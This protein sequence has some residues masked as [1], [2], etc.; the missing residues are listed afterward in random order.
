M[1]SDPLRKALAVVAMLIG[2]AAGGLPV[3]ARAQAADAEPDVGTPSEAAVQFSKWVAASGDNNGVP[4]VIVD[5]IAAVVSVYDSQGNLLGAEPALL[6][7]AHG[8]E[9]APGI[10]SRDLSRISPEERTT[11]AGRFLANFGRANGKQKVLWVDFSTAISL[12]A[13][14]TTNKAEQRLERLQS[15]SADDNRITYGCINVSAQFYEDVV[16]KT[17]EE[18]R[19]V[20]YVMPDTKPVEEVFPSFAIMEAQGRS[21]GLA[22]S[23][24][25]LHA[26]DGA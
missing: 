23:E 15:A 18:T 7:S 4:F 13:V 25:R 8:D 14:V 16:R 2:L 10:G 24:T 5:K 3:H 26:A 9:S 19:G 6:G 11:P 20:V 21:A 1:T 12:H 22:S 17:F